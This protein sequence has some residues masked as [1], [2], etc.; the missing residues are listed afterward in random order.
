MLREAHITGIY[1]TEYQRT[2]QTAKP[3][4]DAL[5]IAM[6]QTPAADEATLVAK[7]HALGRQARVLVVSHADR[8]PDLL[9]LLGVAEN[10]DI[11]ASQYDDVFVLVASGSQQ[12]T[13]IRLKY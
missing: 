13:F 2:V 1:V 7:L 6:V 4:A 3:L 12:P 9:R 5:K 8:L 10:V 11:P